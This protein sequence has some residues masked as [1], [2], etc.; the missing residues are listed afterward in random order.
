MANR[1]YR[2]IARFLQL[3]Q[4]AGMLT[5]HTLEMPR[6]HTCSTKM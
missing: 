3:Y 5:H 2:Q 1:R 6:H 4:G